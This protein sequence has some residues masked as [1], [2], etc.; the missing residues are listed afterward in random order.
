MTVAVGKPVA[1]D[2]PKELVPLDAGLG[3]EPGANHAHGGRVIPGALSGLRRRRVT[4]RKRPVPGSG[5]AALP[6]GGSEDAPY[7]QPFLPQLTVTVCGT[8][9]AVLALVEDAELGL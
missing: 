4:E 8:L 6:R 5:R 3:F 7:G 1:L 2:C 9:V